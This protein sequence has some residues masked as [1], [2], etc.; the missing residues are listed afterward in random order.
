M[1]HLSECGQLEGLPQFKLI[2]LLMTDSRVFVPNIS[3]I[4]SSYDIVCALPTDLMFR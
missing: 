1:G 4:K 2:F 3:Q